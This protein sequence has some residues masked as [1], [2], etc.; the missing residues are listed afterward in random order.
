MDHVIYREYTS[1]EP[2]GERF[3]D[4]WWECPVC[5]AK[6]SMEELAAIGGEE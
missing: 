4:Q 3:D 6:Y 1:V 2:H 5:G